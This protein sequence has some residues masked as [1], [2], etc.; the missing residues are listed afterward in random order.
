MET[1]RPERR[2][3]ICSKISV[4]QVDCSLRTLLTQKEAQVNHSTCQA[5]LERARAKE[6]V[7]TVQLYVHCVHISHL[8]HVEM[9]GFLT[10]QVNWVR[11]IGIGW[12]EADIYL[13]CTIAIPDCVA[14]IP[15]PK[16]CVPFSHTKNIF[17]WKI[18]P[19]LNEIF[20]VDKIEP[21]GVKESLTCR[22]A[23]DLE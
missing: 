8:D 17:R 21:F 1:K 16:A 2:E 14:A 22:F 23:D 10:H 15:E 19:Q 13:D 20:R 9:R 4:V 3:M 5:V 7:F 6:K 11:T 12:V 18:S